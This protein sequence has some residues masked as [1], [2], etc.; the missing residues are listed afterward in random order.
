MVPDVLDI[1]EDWVQVL[2]PLG[3]EK[4]NFR[5]ELLKE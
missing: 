2:H 3:I 5:D 1:F 4:T